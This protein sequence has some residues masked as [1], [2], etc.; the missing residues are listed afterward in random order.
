MSDDQRRH[1]CDLFE[2]RFGR[3]AEWVAVAPG[4]V[5]LIGEHVDYCGGFVLPLAIDRQT[6]IAAAAGPK[7]S[8]ARIRSTALGREVE[9]PLDRPQGPP[10]AAGNDGWSNMIRGVI[11]GFR[12]RGVS[13]PAFDA[14]VDTTVPLGGGL[15]SSA[16]LEVATATLLAAITARKIPPLDLAILCQKAEHDYAGVPCGVMDQCASTLCTADHLL[17][18]DCRSLHAEQVPFV[19]PELVLLV[20]NSNVSH[21]LDDGE[22]AKRRADCEAAARMLDLP[23]LREATP[24]MVDMARERLGPRL[25]ARARH[26]VGEID[27][28]LRVAEAIAA[29]RLDDLGPLMAAS[30]A[31]L[32]DDFEVSC[33]EL[34]LLVD[35]AVSERGVIGSRMT[36]GGFGGCTVTLLEA[37]RAARVMDTIGREYLA[38]TGRQCTMFTTRPAQGAR[39]LP[40]PPED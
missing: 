38:R 22:Y 33:P 5:N 13:I 2:R 11:A 40:C 17:L 16:A 34:D 30:H 35:L 1:V 3:P 4:R 23:L 6:L 26:V 12:G 39:L 28:T 31:S 9:I 29:G 36:G 7:P 14:I 10:V 25:H 18:L 37:A 27:R 24:E 8:V 19:D 15:S 20:T 21:A 32:R